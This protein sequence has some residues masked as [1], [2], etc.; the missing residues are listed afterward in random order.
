VSSPSPSRPASF[1]AYVERMA[2]FGTKEGFVAGLKFKPRSSDVIIAPFGK[3]G[4]TW[5]QQVF[6]GLRTRGDMDFDDIS[7][8]VPWIETAQDLGLDLDAPQ[9]GEPRGFKSHLTYDM[10][11][12]GA[13]YIVSI[14]D[15]KDVL[16]SAFRFAEGWFFEPGSVPIE[17]YARK[18]F[19]QGSTPSRRGDYWQHLASWWPHRHDANVLYMSYE[20]MN[21]DLASTVR[22][23]AAFVGI[24]LDDE[25]MDI[26]MRQS[27]LEFMLAHKDR[28]DD[29]MMRER[30]ERLLGIPLGSDSS[31][32]RKG[33]V[34]E[35]TRELPND[36]ADEMDAIWQREIGATLG[37]ASYVEL[38]DTLERD[39]V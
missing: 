30:S 10:V 39:G 23:V 19:M 18:Q 27:S 34:G 29:A 2:G 36:V 32:V 14:R 21:R 28:F 4:T 24:A 38:T 9:R 7:R 25:L 17:T 8:V 26:V 35:H 37:F 15:P 12:K 1:E 5:L 22:R 31:K 20:A 3:S 33:A 6:H 16:V 11:P 13:R